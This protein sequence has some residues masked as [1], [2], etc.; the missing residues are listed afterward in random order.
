VEPVEVDAVLVAPTRP[1]WALDE[2]RRRRL[3][4]S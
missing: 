4:V 2:A 3:L 1:G